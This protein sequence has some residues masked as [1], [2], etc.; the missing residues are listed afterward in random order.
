MTK[1]KTAST[2]LGGDWKEVVI[3]EY[4]EGA[5][6]SEVRAELSVTYKL[7]QD[8][9]LDD[10]DF[11]EVVTLGRMLSKA[12]WLKEG[13]KN[14]YNK[15]FHA[16]LWYKNMQNRFGWSERQTTNV[17]D[18]D[19]SPEDM[20]DEAIDDKLNEMLKSMNIQVQ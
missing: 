14:L 8:L 19:S 7:W 13:R 16:F 3:R 5:S 1:I 18:M 2:T 20:D 9:L 11:R 15:G 17:D 10:T 12:W 4:S 6:D